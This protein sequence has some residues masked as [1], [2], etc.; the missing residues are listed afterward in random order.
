MDAPEAVSG[1]LLPLQIV[2]PEPALTEGNAFT[3]TVTLAVPEQP[4]ALVPVTVYVR[5]AVGEATGDAQVVQD[6]AIEGDHTY[7]AAPVALSVV[8]APLQMATLEP[9]DT[10]GNE[11]TDT[12]TELIAEQPDVV[13]TTV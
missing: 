4:P 13:P 5:V 3:E 10:D 2:T 9:A 12:V 6:R 11:F 1:V 8:D 7:V